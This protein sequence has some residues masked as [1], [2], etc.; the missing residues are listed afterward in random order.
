MA[1]FTP[2][3]GGPDEN[4]K[5][6]E[7]KTDPPKKKGRVLWIFVAIICV[8]LAVACAFMLGGVWQAG[9]TQARIDEIAGR[10]VTPV[11][12]ATHT[13]APD[14]PPRSEVPIPTPTPRPRRENEREINFAELQSYNP[15][16][17]GWVEVPGTNIDY[18]IVTTLCNYH[19]LDHDLFGNSS[20]HG[21]IYTDIRNAPDWEDPFIILYG[22]N[23][24]DGSKFSNLHRFRDEDFFNENRRII[25]YTPEGQLEFWVFAAYERD[26]A[27]VMGARNFRNRTVMREYLSGIETVAGPGA[28]FDMEN[29]SVADGILTLSTCVTGDYSRR[30]LVQAIFVAP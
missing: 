2:E 28:Q 1:L 6:A 14:G 11:A 21:T 13:P 30:F 25:I 10:P 20:E 5:Q 23:M 22:H 16:V 8:S 27:H 26:D 17:I 9:R 29:V 3:P 7:V 12:I 24:A 4:D 15:D 18:P 19:Y